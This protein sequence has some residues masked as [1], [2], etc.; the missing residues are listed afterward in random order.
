[1]NNA[2]TVLFDVRGG[3]DTTI[4]AKELRG[5]GAKESRKDKDCKDI[6]EA[7]KTLREEGSEPLF[8]A[9]KDGIMKCPTIIPVSNIVKDNAVML[10]INALEAAMKNSLIEQ[11]KQNDHVNSRLESTLKDNV[12]KNFALQMKD[13]DS[14]LE[15]F[16]AELNESKSIKEQT[17]IRNVIAVTEK[18]PKRT[19]DLNIT[20]KK[21]HFNNDN[22][23]Q[24]RVFKQNKPPSFI[25]HYSGLKP[26]GQPYL[27]Y[28]SSA[29]DIG[30]R[31]GHN[32]FDSMNPFTQPSSINEEFNR[33]TVTNTVK[34]DAIRQVTCT[35]FQPIN[36][37]SGSTILVQSCID[38]R[39]LRC[40][41][42]W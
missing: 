20:Y 10:K 31:V 27:P 8:V 4:G 3:E 40:C 41:E 34:D 33:N 26:R 30:D 7:I 1:M 2:K 12:I 37:S 18:L 28:R 24:T 32:V 39:F 42:S 36:S 9:S 6:I 38:R 14:S 16:K 25:S 17:S 15:A 35:A 23:N 5:G 19:G 13:F 22:N 21:V 11:K 29:D